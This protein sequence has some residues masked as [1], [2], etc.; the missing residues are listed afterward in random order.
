MASGL[1]LA[2]VLIDAEGEDVAAGLIGCQQKFAGGVEAEVAWSLAQGR[3]MLHG[4]Q[5]AGLLI[6]AEN[7]NRVVTAI[8]SVEKLPA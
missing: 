7:R 6:D 2:G 5:L 3:L 4:L 1:Q 8:G